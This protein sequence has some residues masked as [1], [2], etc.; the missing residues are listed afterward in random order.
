[1]YAE[2]G[3]T[4]VLA[5]RTHQRAHK[6][7][8]LRLC[9]E[10][11]VGTQF[12]GII[13]VFRKTGSGSMEGGGQRDVQVAEL[14]VLHVSVQGSFQRQRLVGPVVT[15]RLGH[16][17]HELKHVLSSHLGLH[18]QAQQSRVDRVCQVEGH[19]QLYGYLRLRSLQAESGQAQLS[20]LHH[21]RTRQVGHLQTILLP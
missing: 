3:N 18:T 6:V 1:M 5:C 21:D 12:L 19:I 2:R 7:Y 8:V 9:L 17:T 10:L 16:T 14:H 15:E 20:V 11:H 13:Q 4:I